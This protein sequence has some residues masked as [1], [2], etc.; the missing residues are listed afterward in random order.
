MEI[1][2]G[3][4]VLISIFII[5]V[6][7]GVLKMFSDKKLKEMI[8]KVDGI[9]NSVVIDPYTVLIQKNN[10][11][12]SIVGK[13][14]IIELEKD[15]YGTLTSCQ[16]SF[17]SFLCVFKEQMIIIPIKGLMRS[18]T[19][20]KCIKYEDIKDIKNQTIFNTV[21]K[22]K[23][24]GSRVLRGGVASILTGGNLLATGLAAAS[25]GTTTTTS[26]NYSHTQLVIILKKKKGE[27]FSKKEK[28]IFINTSD[29]V[30]LELLI[31]ENM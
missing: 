9:V 27:W 5:Y 26:T 2:I 31:N 6:L 7:Y 11:D 24:S 14:K 19:E 30:K 16:Y 4:M 29:A 12:Y 28:I 20:I 1:V 10:G 21:S 13:N 22:T 23:K 17:N 15:I 3:V 18:S 8:G 25:V